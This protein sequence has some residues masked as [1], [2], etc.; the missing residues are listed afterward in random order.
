[1]GVVRRRA[2]DD[3]GHAQRDRRHRRRRQ[4]TV[5]RPHAHYL[6]GDLGTWGWILVGIGAC[7]GITGFAIARGSDVARWAGVGFA[8]ANA[9]AQLLFM[10]AYPLWSLAI[11][12]VDLLVVYALVIY[13]RPR[14]PP[15]PRAP[16]VARC[17]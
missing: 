6:T 5:L 2:P 14:L 15:V 12:A 16:G 9:L 11:F 7:Q 1:M 17:L 8:L 13:G 4:L 3:V 10:Q